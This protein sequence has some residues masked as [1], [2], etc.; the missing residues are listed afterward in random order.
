MKEN[1]NPYHIYWVEFFPENGKVTKHDRKALGERIFLSNGVTYKKPFASKEAAVSFLENFHA[2]LDKKY[3]C[4]MCT[5]KQ[6]AK[7]SASNG[8]EIPYTEKQKQEAYYI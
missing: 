5:D 6:F 7:A 2:K 8:Y 4:L 1:L 3:K